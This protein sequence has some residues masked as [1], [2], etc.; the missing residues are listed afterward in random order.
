MDLSDLTNTPFVHTVIS[1]GMRRE[2]EGAT[3]GPSNRV[4]IEQ[5]VFRKA[6][7]IFSVSLEEK[8]DLI[9]LYKIDPRRVV[10][11]G[12]L[13]NEVFFRPAHT[14][15]GEAMTISRKTFD[16]GMG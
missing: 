14:E 1:N 10:V 2:L 11:V 12:R 13:V 6:A 8:Q 5:K 3:P 15:L 4:A 16:R 9:S 7:Y